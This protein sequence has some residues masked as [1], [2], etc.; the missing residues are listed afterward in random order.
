MSF[1][2][3]VLAMAG[4]ADHRQACARYERCRSAS[5]DEGA[6]EPG[7]DSF[8]R[9]LRTWF[10]DRPSFSDDTPWADTPPRVGSDH[11]IMRLRYGTAGDLAAERIGDLA[12]HHGLVLFDPQ[13]GEAFFPTPD[14][15]QGPVDCGGRAAC[16]L[17]VKS[18]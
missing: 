3:A 2:L 17:R 11:V 18:T 5:H 14:G 1:D 16:A 8:C 6:S 15:W 10:P 7:I 12:W 13:F 9:E 4:S